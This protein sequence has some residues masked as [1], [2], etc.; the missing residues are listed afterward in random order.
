MDKNTIIGII[1]IFAIFIGFSIYNSSRLNKGYQEAM[2]T[3][4]TEVV[5]G[6]LERA[7]TQYVN[8]LRFKP[9]NPEALAKLDELNIKLGIVPSPEPEKKDTSAVV[10]SPAVTGTAISNTAPDNV[11]QYGIFA[12]AANGEEGFI[13]LENNKLELKISLKGGRVYLPG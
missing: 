12:D 3:A 9:N 10:T 11:N 13:T 7:R 2:K 4:E 6:N 1:L 8:A 5:N